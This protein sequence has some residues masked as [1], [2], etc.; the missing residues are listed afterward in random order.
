MN[1]ITRIFALCLLLIFALGSTSQAITRV[2]RKLYVIDLF[3]GYGSPVGN[4]SAIPGDDFYYDGAIHEF[5]AD[6][7]YDGSFHI[8]IDYG[9]LW[10]N[11]LLT[12]VGFRYVHH[13]LKDTI[14]NARDAFYYNTKPKLNQYDLDL[15]FNYLVT[16]IYETFGS[17]YVG[18]G[19]HGGITNVS[20]EGIVVSGEEGDIVTSSSQ[21]ELTFAMSLNFGAEFKVFTA[22]SGKS[23]VTLASVNSWDFVSTNDRPKYLNIGG[24]IRYYFRM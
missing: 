17:P 19:L 11:H 13:N 4:Y 21:N 12:Q 18:L 7:V 3:S 1:K 15:N 24:A 14:G 6:Q 22:P 8:G 9:Q 16:N 10:A 5:P 2:A 23:F 20:T